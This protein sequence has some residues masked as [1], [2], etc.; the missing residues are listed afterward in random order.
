[1]STFVVLAFAMGLLVGLLLCCCLSCCARYGEAMRERCYACLGCCCPCCCL[2]YAAWGEQTRNAEWGGKPHET[3]AVRGETQMAYDGQWLTYQ[4]GA[5]GFS[6]GAVA[7]PHAAT[8]ALSP[9]SSTPWHHQYTM[10]R[11][12]VLSPR[13]EVR[14]TPWRGHSAYGG[15]GGR[16]GRRSPDAAPKTFA[17]AMMAAGSEREEETG[18]SG[19]RITRV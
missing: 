9:Y 7:T 16:A 12:S 18:A 1:M 6:S 10:G 11:G 5:A 13:G 14:A 3:G 19:G 8:C 2:P 17:E 15:S 4:G